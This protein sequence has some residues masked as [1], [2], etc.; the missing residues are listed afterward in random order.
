MPGVPKL[1][2]ALD[3]CRD[4]GCP[5]RRAGGLMAG[6]RALD[7][8]PMRHRRC[9]PRVRARIALVEKWAVNLQKLTKQTKVVAP[10]S[11][12][13]D[14]PSPFQA[15][16]VSKAWLKRRRRQLRASGF[17]TKE[18]RILRLRDIDRLSWRALAKRFGK[19]REGPRQIYKKVRLRL[20]HPKRSNLVPPSY[21]CASTTFKNRP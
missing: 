2:S 9:C 20:S 18:L 15:R 5:G 4:L 7:P 12:S 13:V 17:T 6:A 16:R 10:S 14:L 21:R 11:P 19:S 3:H 1:Q 8:D